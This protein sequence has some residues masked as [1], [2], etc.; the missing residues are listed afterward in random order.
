MAPLKAQVEPHGTMAWAL[1]ELWQYA[2]KKEVPRTTLKWPDPS[3]EPLPDS[4]GL[5]G[6]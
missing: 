6:D 5:P 4:F 1:N 2:G 3:P